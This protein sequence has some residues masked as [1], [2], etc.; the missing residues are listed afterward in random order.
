MLKMLRPTRSNRYVPSY[1]GLLHPADSLN[2]D[3]Q[4]LSAIQASYTRLNRLLRQDPDP[5]SSSGFERDTSRLVS[6]WIESGRRDQDDLRSERG[7]D[8]AVWFDFVVV[9]GERRDL[10]DRGGWARSRETWRVGAEIDFVP[11]ST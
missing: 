10:L 11:V 3:K 1:H 8:G 7:E 6:S 9:T 5:S 2:R 4:T